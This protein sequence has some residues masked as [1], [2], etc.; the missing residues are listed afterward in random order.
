VVIGVNFFLNNHLTFRSARLKGLKMVFGLL[1]FYVACG[2]GLAINAEFSQ[3]FRSSGVPWYGAATIGLAAGSL[4]NFWMSS[5]FV[6]E[7]SRR[8]ARRYVPRSIDPAA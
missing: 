2:F 5:L 1:L 8:R 6:W 3:V 4:W 7:V